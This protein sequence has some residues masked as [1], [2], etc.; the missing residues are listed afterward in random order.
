M[1][2][3]YVVAD[4][5]GVALVVVVLGALLWVW[6]VLAWSRWLS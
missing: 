4:R 3:S 5:L 2:W 1:W 6:A